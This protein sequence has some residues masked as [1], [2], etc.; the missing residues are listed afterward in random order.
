[1]KGV[2]PWRQLR[3][4]L[5]T[6]LGFKQLGFFIPYRYAA[7][8]NE[9]QSYPALEPFFAAG[10]QRYE[11]LLA[12][13]ETYI[14]QL[15]DFSRAPVPPPRLD[16]DWFPRLDAIAAYSLV[17]RCKPARVFEI[18]S[19]HST[20]FFSLA[21][22]DAGL[23]TTID[24]IDPSPRADIAQLPNVTLHQ[25]LLQDTPREFWQ[26]VHEG[27]FVSLDG[28]HILMP[29]TDVDTYLTS[30]L[31]QIAGKATLHIHDITLPDAYPKA[32]GWR[33]YNEQSAVAGLIASGAYEVLWSS[34]YVTTRMGARLGN[35]P[36]SDLPCSDNA[37]E[38]SLWLTPRLK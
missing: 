16:Q 13:A 20:R 29:G 28:S 14:D 3:F 19:G 2:K 21:V 31:P 36:L 10:E 7:Q 38:T 27:D 32:W 23:A 26:E 33:G 11:D 17:R 18:G 6:L 15:T 24:T 25:N 37:I 1:M 9:P 35:S 34:H 30:V 8:L 4:G 22:A 5:S 12:L